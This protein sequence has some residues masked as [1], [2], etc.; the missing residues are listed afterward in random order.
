MARFRERFTAISSMNNYEGGEFKWMDMH[1]EGQY[2]IRILGPKTPEKLPFMEVFYHK[3]LDTTGGKYI[4]PQMTPM[5]SKPCPVCEQ[6]ALLAQSFN[7][8]D[9]E[10]AKSLEPSLSVYCNAIFV[11]RRQDVNGMIIDE[12]LAN[13]IY[14]YTIYIQQYKQILS[15]YNNPM[16][17]DLTDWEMGRNISIIKSKKGKSKYFDTI[18]Q[19]DGG[20]TS[21]GTPELV[22]GLKSKLFDLEVFLNKIKTYDELK[23]I[24][25]YGTAEVPAGAQQPV[26]ATTAAPTY[27]P[28]PVAAQPVYAQP[29]PVQ[30]A[31]VY[32]PAPVQPV[33]VAV[34]PVAAQPVYVQPA[35]VAAV[36]PAPVAYVPA[37]L[38]VAPAPVEPAQAAQV[39]SEL[40]N[41]ANQVMSQ[42]VPTYAPS[43]VAPVAVAPAPVAA[44]AQATVPMAAPV[45]GRPEGAGECFAKDYNEFSPNCVIC[46]FDT[47]CVKAIS[48]N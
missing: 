42:P 46:S 47:A 17:G 8:D 41:V 15:Y 27:A 19:P 7:P 29:A 23:N 21:I 12:P 40:Q 32:A 3:N 38:P 13:Q 48:G 10:L 11:N 5:I 35:P 4:C 44:V 9:R 36:A 45:G 33:P 34:A 39:V 43:P 20:P 28:A 14:I 25:Q 6:R 2:L 37:P 1:A 24:L 22:A 16:W 31:P 26:P 30:P 18:T